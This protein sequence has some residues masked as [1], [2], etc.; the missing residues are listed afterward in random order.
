[1]EPSLIGY[2]SEFQEGLLSLLWRQWGSLG[3]SGHAAAWS[4]TPLDP[5]ALLLLSC[6]V[7]RRDARLFDAMLDWL[8]VNGRY[9][10]VHRLRRVVA[11][12]RF[13]GGAVLGAIAAT[14]SNANQPLKWKLASKR[15]AVQATSGDEPLFRLPDGSPLP[16]LREPDPRFLAHG[17]MRDL[18]QPREA[19]STF[20]PDVPANLLLRLRAFV[21]VSARC[22]ILAYLLLNRQGS[23]S[24]VAKAWGYYTATVTKALADMGDSGFVV[25]RVEGRRRYYAIYPD[26]W[27]QLLIGDAAPGWISWMGLYAALERLWVFL[28][29]PD[30]ASQSPLA[31]SSALRRIL[32]NG[33]SE[34]LA[35]SG[36][37]VSF[38]GADRCAGESL[39]PFFVDRTRELLSALHALG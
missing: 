10:N 29:A 26:A 25:S 35:Q 32:R 24:A 3:V 14:L 4:R 23:P 34:G 18:Y 21:G 27:R 9:I 33:V 19:A 16:V 5:E 38:G 1:M 13:S 36:V 28:S 15:Q 11:S 12:G 31:Q 20:R 39:V 8:R 6:T 22:E 37:M 2:R 7:A 30:L 17:L